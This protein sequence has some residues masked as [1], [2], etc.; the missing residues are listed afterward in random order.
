MKT[1]NLVLDEGFLV[2]QLS[3]SLPS[4]FQF[5]EVDKNNHTFRSLHV[6]NMRKLILQMSA[7]ASSPISWVSQQLGLY[8]LYT[9]CFSSRTLPINKEPNFK[10]IVS[11]QIQIIFKPVVVEDFIFFKQQSHSNKYSYCS[12]DSDQKMTSTENRSNT[13]KKRICNH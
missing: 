10:L 8:Y 11:N 6:A 3:L 1:Q 2:L 12:M 7:I 13:V 9:G 4:A 5:R